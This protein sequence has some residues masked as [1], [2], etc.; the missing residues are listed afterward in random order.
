MP[1]VRRTL[2]LVCLSIIPSATSCA[3][4][5]A[6]DPGEVGELSYTIWG[7]SGTVD[8]QEIW[9]STAFV[10][11]EPTGR[12]SCNDYGTMWLAGSLRLWKEPVI[13][14]D[15][16]IGM[17]ETRCK[18]FT[19]NEFGALVMT[20]DEAPLFVYEGDH[21]SGSMVETIPNNM[22]PIG[23]R[24]GLSSNS[25]WVRDIAM[26]YG[27][28]VGG[29]IED[30][31]SPTVGGWILDYGGASTIDLICDD[32]QVLEGITVRYTASSG[33]IRQ[34]RARCATATFTP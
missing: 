22:V 20:G 14:P 21:R 5:D 31:I 7:V 16:F 33:K 30:Y 34:V 9:T 3:G 2:V 18:E 15:N 4:E 24:L 17:M 28:G 11:N 25:Q 19:T 27:I 23:M 29:S 32:Q 13:N 10:G 8:E 1:N 6:I 12:G 26:L